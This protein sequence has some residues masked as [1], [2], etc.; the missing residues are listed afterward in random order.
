M[1]RLNITMPEEV[2][3]K[4]RHIANKSQFIAQA[5]REKFLREKRREL[6]RLLAES[7]QKAAQE[8]MSANRDWENPTLTDG[9]K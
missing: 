7:Y 5:V 6:E 9:W 1:V 2:A 4:L 3:E 8:D